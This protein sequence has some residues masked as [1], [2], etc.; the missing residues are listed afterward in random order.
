MGWTDL[1]PV[2]VRAIQHLRQG[3]RDCIISSPTA[4]G[5]TEAA[6]LPILSA[7]AD[8]PMGS[9][10]AMY[11]GPLKALINDQFRRLE[12]LCQR[13][14]VPVHKWHGD[15]DSS[16]RQR[17]T[18]SPSGVLLITPESLEAMFV[19]RATRLPTLFSRLDYVVIDELH[20]FLE[21]E[22][23]AQVR[24]LLHRLH[25]RVGC[26]PVRV[27]LSATIAEPERALAWLRPDGPPA[28]LILDGGGESSVSLRVRGIWKRPPPTP[29][30]TGDQEEPIDDPAMEELARSILLACRGKTNLAFANSK[31]TIELLADELATQATVMGLPDEVVVHHGSLSKA[32]R[33]YAESRLRDPR[34]C[35][36]VCSNT[37]EMGIDIGEVDEIVQVSAPWSVAS[38]VQRLGRSGR[39]A[40]TRRTLR[41]YFV[42]EA[43][44]ADLDTWKALHLSFLQ[45]VAIV[46]L[47]LARFLEPANTQRAHLSTLI[48]QTLSTIAE[49]GGATARDLFQ[50]VTG[51]ATFG[52]VKQTDFAEILRELG[53]RKVVE[54][55]EDGTIILGA[56]GERLVEHYS[57]YAAFNAPQELRVIAGSEE[58]GA[59]PMPPPPG[60]HLVLAGRRWQVDQVDA[61]RRE[62]LVS[63]AKGR[64]PPWFPSLPGAVHR[65]VHEKMRELAAGSELPSYLDEIA[66]E[67][68]CNARATAAQCRMFQPPAQELPGG[69]RLFVWAGSRIQLTL[70]I[71]LSVAKLR[72]GDHGVGLDVFAD[73]AA[74]R[75]ALTSFAR[76]PNEAALGAFADVNLL[77]RELGREKYE[78]YVPAD[79]WRAVFVRE[80]LD[81]P[82]AVAVAGQLAV[83][84]GA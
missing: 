6:F 58:I 73:R 38:L 42:E 50:R 23:G 77:M 66:V 44:G 12:D 80:E 57:F 4:S 7:I 75:Q 72:H 60:E 83:A 78:G 74:V 71:A 11:I 52:V 81:V 43:P 36:A 40:A 19:L 56:V 28:T 34:P 18:R 41:A 16:A 46:E 30:E 69:V 45:G 32:Q 5:K 65:A 2:Q 15:V 24:S 47:M 35:T 53:R 82:G 25:V 31:G 39:R 37:L 79:L 62:V 22:R 51:A 10:R 76:A 8:D 67:M 54:Q 1:H 55:A 68:L 26:D 59:I 63:R 27:G 9:V 48:H 61:T 17:L 13:M 33:E 3:G 21:T 14:E 64:K 70:S 20:A 29:A 49:T 84:L